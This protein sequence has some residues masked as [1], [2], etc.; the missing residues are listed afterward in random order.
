MIDQGHYGQT[1]WDFVNTFREDG[2]GQICCPHKNHL[3]SQGVG[4]RSSTASNSQAA[5]TRL[6]P[7]FITLP[8]FFEPIN[9]Y[10]LTN[11]KWNSNHGH[12][13]F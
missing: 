7:A 12:L 9:E 8:F 10:A 13:S 2:F 1:K 5:R 4:G 11:A 3:N 6:L